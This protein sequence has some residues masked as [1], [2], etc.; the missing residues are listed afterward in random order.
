MAGRMGRKGFTLIEASLATVII[1]VGV[2]AMMQLFTTC[3]QENQNAAQTSTAIMLAGNIQEIARGMAFN[4]PASGRA[5]FGPEDD[6]I[7]DLA[8]YDDVDD[9]DLGS[10]NPPLDATGQPVAA[11]SQYT[12][13]V[14]VMPVFKNNLGSNTDITSPTIPKTTYT[15]A[16]RVRVQVLYRPTAGAPQRE[17]HRTSWTHVDR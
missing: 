5:I 16:V 12:Q 8:M 3:T 1:S 13:V 4:D 6:E 10:F 11:L 15:E 14:T 2:M 9:L 7:G 17:V